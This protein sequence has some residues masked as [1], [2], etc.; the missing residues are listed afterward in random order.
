MHRPPT[1]ASVDGECTG[2][3][4]HVAVSGCR[5]ASVGELQKMPCLTKA[6]KLFE[7]KKSR[8]ATTAEYHFIRY[9]VYLIKRPVN[10]KQD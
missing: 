9:K 8:W 5:C 6:Q 1:A 3:Q 7:I 2:G 10:V 4:A